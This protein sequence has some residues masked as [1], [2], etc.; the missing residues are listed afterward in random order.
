MKLTGIF[1]PARNF[2]H[3]CSYVM[4]CFFTTHCSLRV[5]VRSVLDG[6]TFATRRK[7]TTSDERLYF[8]SEGRRAEDFF[9]LKFRRRWPGVNP[10]TWVPKVSTLPLDHRS[11]LCSYV[12]MSAFRFIV[13]VLLVLLLR[14]LLNKTECV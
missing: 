12:G 10:R 11:R 9:A 4:L 8:P 6:P 7:A 13:S 14:I 2:S 3:Q 5:I 1:Y